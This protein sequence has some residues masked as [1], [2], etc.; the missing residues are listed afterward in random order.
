MGVFSADGVTLA[1][2]W[3]PDDNW[4]EGVYLVRPADGALL[5][6]LPGFGDHWGSMAF[7]LDGQ[8]LAVGSQYGVI[9]LWRVQDGMLLHT[10]ELCPG[11]ATR[12]MMCLLLVTDLAFSSD[13]T[14][15]AVGVGGVANRGRDSAVRLWSVDEGTLLATLEGHRWDIAALAFSPDGT[16]LATG[17]KDGTIRLWGVL[18]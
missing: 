11:C 15:L 7:S 6:T 5:H 13:G 3:G 17:S 4:D 14:V 2:A 18:P 8:I 16:L 10:L 9:R 1:Y 12:G